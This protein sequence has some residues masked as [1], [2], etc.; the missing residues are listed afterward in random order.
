MASRHLQT[1][2]FSKFNQRLRFFSGDSKRLFQIN[3]TSELKALLGELKMTLWRR[4]NVDHLRPS[5]SEHFLQIRK[6]FGNVKALAQLFGH[7]Q[8][9]VAD[10]N[11]PAI[12]NSTNGGNVLI[13]HLS[14]S[15][16]GYAKHR[17]LLWTSNWPR[18]ASIALSILTRGC[19]CNRSF[20]F[21]F[22]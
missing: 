6:A 21:L 8:F 13:C 9:P 11:Y 22:E 2:S 17:Y 12:S 20:S 16:Y 10:R 14:T 5:S 18:N 15:D 4:C 1:A 3:V 19:H 7:Q